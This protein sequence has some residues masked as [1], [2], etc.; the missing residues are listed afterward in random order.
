[1]QLLQPANA[2]ISTQRSDFCNAIRMLINT[3]IL[4]DRQRQCRES[5]AFAYKA[6]SASGRR[7]RLYPA[8]GFAEK[9]INR[10]AAGLGH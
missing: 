8:S 9:E 6:V 3:Q 2:D 1:L 5:A 10:A 4:T 7:P